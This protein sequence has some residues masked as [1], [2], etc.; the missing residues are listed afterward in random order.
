MSAPIKQHADEIIRIF[1][2]KLILQESAK[3]SP[4]SHP[5]PLRLR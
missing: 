2:G 4:P 1:E 3:L 5:L